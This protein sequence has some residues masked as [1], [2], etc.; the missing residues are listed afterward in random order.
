MCFSIYDNKAS[1][2]RGKSLLLRKQNDITFGEEDVD[3]LDSMIEDEIDQCV[4]LVDIVDEIV[5]GDGDID[6]Y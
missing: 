4:G 6:I 3:C 5:G 1:T 2:F